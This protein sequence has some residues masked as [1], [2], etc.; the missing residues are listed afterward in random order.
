MVEKPVLGHVS[1]QTSVA[2]ISTLPISSIGTPAGRRSPSLESMKG[3][4][5]TSSASH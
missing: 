5:L 3:R 1:G 4:G 2:D